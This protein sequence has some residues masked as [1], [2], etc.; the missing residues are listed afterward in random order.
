ML[1]TAIILS[2]GFGKRL[3]PL[4]AS[5]PKPLIKLN[6]KC[7]ID[8][9]I[10]KL[11]E[12]GFKRILVNTHYLAEQ[13]EDHISSLNFPNVEISA[14]RENKILGT[15]GG[16]LNAMH[17]FD[18]DEI[19]VINAD[20][21]FSDRYQIKKLLTLWEEGN[22]KALLMLKDKAKIDYP[23]DGDFSLSER[24]FLERSS[25][26]YVFTGIAS[27]KRDLF[28][29]CKLQEFSYIEMID[30]IIS[31]GENSSIAGV[32]LEGKWLDLGTQERLAQAGAYLKG[33]K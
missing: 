8:Y 26:K 33:D 29:G 6:S 13:I 5:T 15:G 20:I 11:V 32:E 2:A 4:T 9:Q 27:L 7:L 17:L 30:N 14:I 18:L 16:I 19:L 12:L 28:I 25:K 1:E 22:F 10:E 3:L 21:Y 24:N 23:T 31:N